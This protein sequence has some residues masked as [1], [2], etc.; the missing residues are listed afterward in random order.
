MWFEEKWPKNRENQNIIIIPQNH[1]SKSLLV[2]A[3]TNKVSPEMNN[4]IGN[5]KDEI[6]NIIY[7]SKWLIIE[8]NLLAMFNVSE[9]LSKKLFNSDWSA[10]H[11]S[12]YE[13]NEENTMI[14][15]SIKNTPNIICWD[16][17]SLKKSFNLSAILVI[18]YKQK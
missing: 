4:R 5:I 1:L 16:L 10:F 6:P 7:I 15:S 3:S 18:V 11:V 8:P 14:E 17:D 2:L 12:K 13:T 9:S